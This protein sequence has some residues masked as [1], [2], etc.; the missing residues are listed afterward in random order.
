MCNLYVFLYVLKQSWTQQRC[1]VYLEDLLHASKI[2]HKGWFLKTHRELKAPFFFL[3][4][5]VS[6]V[7]EMFCFSQWTLRLDCRDSLKVCWADEQHSQYLHDIDQWPAYYLQ[8]FSDCYVVFWRKLWKMIRFAFE[9]CT[10]FESARANQLLFTY[11]TLI[12]PK[13]S[14]AVSNI[15]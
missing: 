13:E 9:D 5:K 1:I 8:I 14:K 12:S 3:A 6:A 15:A 7:S 2:H 4:A 11:Y 10:I